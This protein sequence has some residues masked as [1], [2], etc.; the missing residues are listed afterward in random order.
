MSVK[1]FEPRYMKLGILTAALQELTPRPVRDADPDRAIELI[2]QEGVTLLFGVT[3][4]YLALA[5][6]RRFAEADLS[7][8][9]SALSGGAP[10]P[11]SLLQKEADHIEGFAPECA[12]VTEGGREP[13]EERYAIRP[14]SEA[15]ICHMY[16]RP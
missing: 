4:M 9:R 16:S 10:I 8:L 13:L 12:W 7:T 14:T 1:A 2:E 15:I 3:S 5:A 6:T 11:E